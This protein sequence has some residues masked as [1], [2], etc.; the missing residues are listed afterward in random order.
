MA[1]WVVG[2][3]YPG[4]ARLWSHHHS[5]PGCGPHAQPPAPQARSR[6]PNPTATC[7]VTWARCWW[8]PRGVA[9]PA[10]GPPSAP[11]GHDHADEESAKRFVAPGA[12]FH[13]GLMRPP[14]TLSP[15]HTST[16]PRITSLSCPPISLCQPLVHLSPALMSPPTHTHT[17]NE[18]HRPSSTPTTDKGCTRAGGS[19]KRT[20]PPVWG[21][22]WPEAC[23]VGE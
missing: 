6:P 20:P 17:R 12:A 3:G 13:N 4:C 9:G 7:P 5:R 8:R 19:F 16:H 23:V 21:A 11:R 14:H 2:G 10:A 15:S 1:G 22:A 18:P